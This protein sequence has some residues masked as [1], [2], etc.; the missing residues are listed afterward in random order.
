MVLVIFGN[1][2]EFVFAQLGSEQNSKGVFIGFSEVASVVT[3]DVFMSV[4]PQVA[5]LS[6]EI[7]LSFILWE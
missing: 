3:V 6:D 7:S 2:A 5:H 4:N 1:I